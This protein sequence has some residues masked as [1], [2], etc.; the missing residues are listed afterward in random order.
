MMP[1]VGRN[2]F[3]PL[4]IFFST[5]VFREEIKLVGNDVE[6]EEKKRFL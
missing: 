2:S 1:F 5:T 6:R 3:L 4:T